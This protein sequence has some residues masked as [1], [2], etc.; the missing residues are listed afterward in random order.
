MTNPPSWKFKYP[1]INSLHYSLQ[2]L[3]TVD[4]PYSEPPLSKSRQQK[5]TTNISNFLNVVYK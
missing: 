1:H 5:L 3:P 2:F 4:C